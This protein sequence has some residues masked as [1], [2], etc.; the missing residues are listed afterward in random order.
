MKPF[1]FV[2][3]LLLCLTPSA[4]CAPAPA[5]E[6]LIT[7]RTGK[8]VRWQK[9]P[10]SRDEARRAVDALLARPL[11][12]DTAAQIALLNNPMLRAAFEDIGLSSADL[13]QAGLLQNPA[14]EGSVRFPNSPADIA[15]SLT[16]NLLDALTLPLRKRIAEERLRQSALHV[17][18]TAIQ[19]IADT[20]SAF[21]EVQAQQQIFDGAKQI[22]DSADAAL[23]LARQ[24]YAAAN[25]SDLQLSETK[26]DDSQTR[27]EAIASRAQF[28]AKR[29]KLNRLL[30]LFGAA[31]DWK[32][33]RA[34]SAPPERDFSTTRLTEVALNRRFDF[35]AAQAELTATARNLGLTQKTRWIGALEI[36]ASGERDADNNIRTGPT[37][38]LELP[39]FDQGQ[40]RVGRGEAQ[41]RQAARRLE[42]LAED[43][44]IDVREQCERVVAARDASHLY[45]D[46]LLPERRHIVELML[47]QTNGMY[48]GPY[49][50]LRS[51]RSQVEA[52]RGAIEANRDYWVARTALERAVGGNLDA[53]SSAETPRPSVTAHGK[54]TRKR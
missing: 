28:Q 9:D 47:L 7:T 14:L 40:A 5:A 13:L 33:A 3:A 26:A 27:L 1:N 4:L 18:D 21:Y 41:L 29:E 54:N 37:L 45:R 8:K 32:I 12:A 38:R 25:I 17:A 51:R 35:A 15:G 6:N 48:A 39:I 42:S 49:E 44:R 11:T 43:I 31:S 53:S 20:K 19:L 24:Q 10:A 16:A 30:G 34:L 2:L 46:D 50:L 22:Q 36:G 52:E 23:E